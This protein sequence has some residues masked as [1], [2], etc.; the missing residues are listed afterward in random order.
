MCKQF[1]LPDTMYIL[2]NDYKISNVLKNQWQKELKD[3][4]NENT[5]NNIINTLLKD[6][7]IK[8]P[9]IFAICLCAIKE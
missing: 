7:A 4:C 5:C 2:Y 3:S 6:N 9:L 8:F 1:C